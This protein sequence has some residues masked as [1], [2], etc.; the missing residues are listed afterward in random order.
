MPVT[1]SASKKIQESVDDDDFRLDL[2]TDRRTFVIS[3]ES[4]IYTSK[5]KT[6]LQIK[7]LFIQLLYCN[8]SCFNNNKEYEAL[9]QSNTEITKELAKTKKKQHKLK[10]E[11]VDLRAREYKLCKA[12]NALKVNAKIFSNYFIYK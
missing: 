10:S 8:F 11:I 1:R 2:S 7:L 5:Q 9:K 3:K 12:N 6:I 4:T